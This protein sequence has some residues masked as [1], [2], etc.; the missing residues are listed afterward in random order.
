M[1]FVSIL[2]QTSY[3]VEYRLDHDELLNSTYYNV[4]ASYLWSTVILIL[5]DAFTFMLLLC[6]CKLYANITFSD[7]YLLCSCY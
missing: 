2:M 6:F 3:G 7:L 5:C 4:L 1:T